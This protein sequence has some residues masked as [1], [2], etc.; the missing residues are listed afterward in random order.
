M[1][2]RPPPD[3]AESTLRDR[4][5]GTDDERRGD[6]RV[7]DRDEPPRGAPVER[8]CVE[9]DQHAETDRDRRR[10][11]RQHQAD[12]EHPTAAAEGADRD[13]GGDADH[14]R[15]RRGP[16]GRDGG[17]LEGS[18]R[19]DAETESGPDLVVAQRAPRRQRVPVLEPQRTFDERQEWS[20][21]DRG[22]DADSGADREP[23]AAHRSSATI[24]SGRHESVG[25]P[26]LLARRPRD[27]DRQHDE[28]DDRQHRRSADV[29]ELG[30]T[31]PDLHLDRRAVRRTEHADHTE[32]GEREQE[33]DGRGR[34]DRRTEQRQRDGPEGGEP[35]GSERHARVLEIDGDSFPRG[36]DGPDD[37]REVERDVC[38]QDRPHAA[39]ERVGQ[40]RDEGG[41][42]DDGRQDEDRRQGAR[43][44]P[45]S[46]EV[47]ARDGPG[48]CQADPDRERGAR[49]GLPRGEP[50]HP[51]GVGTPERSR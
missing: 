46:R 24:V 21:H 35:P 10:T 37:D 20:Q 43:Q 26:A 2:T 4:E 45:S 13:H 3:R 8:W 16:D 27:H 29:T 47:E 50:E 17:T 28:L 22:R 36:A 49:C 14:E 41:A 11:E 6:E 1:W 30:H 51:P 7:T 48:R 33:H 23:V 34:R 40:Q 12:V 15:E 42:D 44:C 31:P 32:R 39:V 38:A 25:V 18:E 5:C 19:V 9:R